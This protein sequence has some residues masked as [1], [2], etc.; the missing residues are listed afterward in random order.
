MKEKIKL[1][2]AI[3]T[4]NRPV[5]VKRAIKS[6]YTDDVENT[7]IIIWDNNSIEQNRKEVEKYCLE[8][9]NKVKYF[10][11]KK[12]LGVAGGRN[13]A[14]KQCNGEY[15]FFLDDDAIIYSKDF[16]VKLI[17]YMDNHRY[18]GAA[19]VDIKEPSTNTNHNCKF[20]MTIDSGETIIWC[21]VGG[22]HI[23]KKEALNLEKLYPQRLMFGSE[24]MYTSFLLW[25]NGYEIHEVSELVVLHLPS[26]VNR[27]EGKE[28]DKNF[29]TNQYIVKHL[30]Y[31][32][33]LRLICYCFFR[34]RLLKNKIKYKECKSLI[35]ERYDARDKKTITFKC[36]FGLVKKFGLLPLI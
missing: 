27:I 8:C 23:V 6:C 9:G 34:I 1:S 25:N 12:N 18:V 31:P 21:F 13:A 10:F 17:S 15:V 2:I 7:E 30:V 33:E 3:I 24:E 19:S 35:K 32:V 26:T 20:R 29:L 11:S 4:Y 36:W 22:A 5:E 14:W 28:R 16:F